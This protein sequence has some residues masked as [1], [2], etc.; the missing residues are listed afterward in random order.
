MRKLLAVLITFTLASSAFA[1][2][3]ISTDSMTKSVKDGSSKVVE[4]VK[5]TSK[6]GVQH[7]KDG[8]SKSYEWSKDKATKTTTAVSNTVN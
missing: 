5:T 6:T 1:D 4:K 2:F 3:T 7:V 8:T